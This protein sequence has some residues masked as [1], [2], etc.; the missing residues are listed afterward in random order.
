ML[1]LLFVLFKVLPSFYYRH[2]VPI[3]L[4]HGPLHVLFN[5]GARV[6]ARVMYFLTQGRLGSCAGFLNFCQVFLTGPCHVYKYW[7]EQ[8][9]G[10][11]V[12]SVNPKA[13]EDNYLAPGSERSGVKRVLGYCFTLYWLK[14]IREIQV[15]NLIP[16]PRNTLKWNFFLLAKA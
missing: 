9:R 14:I 12:I 15:Q 16:H 10:P 5:Q 2:I 13:R 3:N 6:R 7:V 4:F 8:Y 1:L 11:S